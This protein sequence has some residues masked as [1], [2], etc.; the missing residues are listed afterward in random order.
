MLLY[1]IG[2]ISYYI[3]VHIDEKREFNKF[4]QEVQK[5]MRCR[6]FLS[7]LERY[8]ETKVWETFEM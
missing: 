2:N 7:R 8:D 5:T 3:K 1:F 4:E 6:S